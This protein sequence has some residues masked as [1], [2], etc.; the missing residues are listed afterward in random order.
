M[1]RYKIVFE[2]CL[3]PW[4]LTTREQIKMKSDAAIVSYTADG[5]KFSDGSDLKADLIVFG[6]GFELDMSHQIARIFGSEVAKQT[7][8]RWTMDDEGEMRGYFKPHREF[9]TVAFYCFEKWTDISTLQM[10]PYGFTAG[11]RAWRDICQGSWRYKSRPPCS[12]RH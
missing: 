11:H 10:A 2:Y 12:E 3:R 7:D 8:A 1:A 4:W 6:T 5:L 9:T